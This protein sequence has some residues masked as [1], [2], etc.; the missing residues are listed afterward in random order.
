MWQL[1]AARTFTLGLLFAGVGCGSRH[2][3]GYTTVVVPRLLANGTNF[4]AQEV[5]NY[6]MAV[7]GSQVGFGYNRRREVRLPPNGGVYI[8][9]STPEQFVTV[10]KILETHPEYPL[11]IVLKEADSARQPAPRP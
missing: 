9:V 4:W 1:A 2:Y 7:S 5:T 3:F 10:R 11:C 6:G 8:E